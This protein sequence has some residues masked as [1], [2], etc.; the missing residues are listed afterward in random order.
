MGAKVVDASLLA[1]LAFGEGRAREAKEL[2]GN[3]RLYA[4]RLMGYE[5]A[6]VAVKKIA[7]QPKDK[8]TILKALELALRLEVQWVDV[9]L[10]AVTK[11]AVGKGL[12]AYDASYLYVSVSLGIP[13][14]TF[15]EKLL[16]RSVK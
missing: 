13:L 9:D 6:H 2:L 11:L 15:D 16:S 5:L 10:L 4:P 12:T 14:V 1:A 3:D 8:E 7:R